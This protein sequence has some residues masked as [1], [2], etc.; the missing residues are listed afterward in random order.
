MS[1]TI[2]T[3]LTVVN[4]TDLRGQAILNLIKTYISGLSGRYYGFRSLGSNDLS[5]PA[6]MVE[7]DSQNPAM[8]TTGKYHLKFNFSIFWFVYDNSP[9]NVITLCTSVEEAMIKLFSNDALGDLQ[10]ANPPTNRF[11]QYPGFWL[12]SEMTSVEISRT[13]LNAYPN[14][15]R[16]MRAG[17]LH[18]MVED[19]VIK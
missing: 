2:A 9:E 17:I 10:T 4:E 12:T 5:F 15:A 19:V 13:I 8:L 3:T 7:P 14:R 11:K 18:L 6:V 1:V 16:Y